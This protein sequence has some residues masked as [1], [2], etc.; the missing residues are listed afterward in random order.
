MA[1]ITMDYKDWV[2]LESWRK[3][4]KAKLIASGLAEKGLYFEFA[5][6]TERVVSRIEGRS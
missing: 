1:T 2:E 6:K 5:L 4:V 3:A